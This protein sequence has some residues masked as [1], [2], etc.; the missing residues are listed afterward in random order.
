VCW[1][2]LGSWTA[3]FNVILAIPTSIVGAFIFMKLLGFTLN[4]FSLLGL[5]L[6]IG[7][8]VD[9][10]IIMLENIVRYGQMGWDRVNAAY[11]GS[12]EITFAVIATS[13]ALISLFVPI[14]FLGGIEGKFFFEFAVTI[15]IAIALSS[16][17]ALTLTPMRCSLVLDTK[18]GTSKFR[19][20]FDDAL[21][22]LSVFYAKSLSRVVEHKGLTLLMASALIALSLVGAKFMKTEF[23]PTQ[24]TGSLRLLFVAPDG[25]S[26]AYTDERVRKFEAIAMKHPDV[27]RVFVAVGGFGGGGQGNRGNGFVVLRDQKER[28]KGQIEVAQE[29]RELSK[30]IDGIKIII[31][32]RGRSAFSGGRGNAVEFTINGPDPQ[33]QLELFNGLKD[34]MEESKDFFSV[35][36]DDATLLPELQIIPDREK[37]L[38]TGVEVNELASLINAAF[39]GATAGKMTQGSRRNEIFVQMKEIDRESKEDISA[40]YI[41][42]NHSELVPVG[43]VV[44]F[45]NTRTP[46]YVYREDRVRGIRVDGSLAPNVVLGDAVKEI[47]TWAEKIFPE[48]YLVRF[49]QSPDEKLFEIAWIMILGLIVAYMVLASQFNSFV[50]PTVVFLAIPFGIVGSLFALL[51]GGFTLNVYSA[52]GIMLTMGIVKKNSILLVEFSNQLRDQ[53]KESVNAV[54]EAARTRLRPILMTTAATLAAAVPPALALGPGA[55]TRIPMALTV[56]GG[57]IVSTLFT[58]YVVP[59]AYLLLSRKRRKVLIEK[60]G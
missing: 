25:K 42:N 56:I 36:S 51:L 38:Q 2:F 14:T 44:K 19:K 20:A 12:R 22:A 35:R 28:K 52:I 27:A 9:D 33:K 48:G 10:A 32:D 16:I 29:L 1:M 50:D 59:C 31:N 3:T 23:A 49:K 26:M 53:G 58:L 30:S 15:S 34:K 17:E 41:R 21:D 11:K 39:S 6:A 37:A 24:D 57:V 4:T 8:V 47:K 55:E 54:V 40:L 18:P 7:I 13:L 45:E 46:Q 60:E 5:T 43:N